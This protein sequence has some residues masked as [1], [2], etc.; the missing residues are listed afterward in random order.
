MKRSPEQILEEES[1]RTL[2]SK[3]PPAWIIRDQTPDVG[4]DMEI[5]IVEN[6]EVTNKLLWLQIKATERRKHSVK[7][8]T[9]PIET[10]HLEY[11]DNCH[12]PVIIVYGIKKSSNEFD[13]YYL[14]AQRYINEYLSKNNPN[15]KEQ[16]SVTLR[17]DK[18]LKVNELDSIATDG[19]LY[20]AAQQLYTTPT[21]AQNWLDG[22]PRSDDKELKERT[23]KGFLYMRDEN[24]KDAIIEFEK[25]LKFC[26]ITQTEKLAILLSIGNSYYPLGKTEDAL[27]FYKAIIKL[28]T[29]V[30]KKDAITGRASA[31]NN[32]GLIYY[33]KGD[34][35]RAQ[36]YYQDALDINRKIGYK[37]GEAGQLGNIGLIYYDKGDLERAQKYYQD[38]LDIDRR[39]GYKQGEAIQLGNIGLIYYVKGDLEGAQKYYQDALDINR[40]IGHKQGEANQLGNIG[41]IYY[42]K[43]DLE[44]ALKYYQDALDIDRRI[45]YKQGEAKDLSVIGL[46]Y[47]AKGDLNNALKFLKNALNILHKSHLIHERDIIQKSIDSITKNIQGKN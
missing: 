7:K 47:K 25:I 10:K 13:F 9:L 37:E 39:I 42:V 36:K 32:I 17:L 38:A 30:S 16:K 15:W 14:F 19:Y 5:E 12:L 40:E 24:Y 18:E 4:I 8:I 26:A 6:G 43:G 29:K 41:L 2:K 11:Y 28:T 22:I 45:G 20:I 23:L 33:D 31:L 34:L 46:I 3:L 35:E 21:G 27:D 44:R 1:R